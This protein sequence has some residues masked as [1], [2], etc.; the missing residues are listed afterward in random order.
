MR[1]SKGNKKSNFGRPVTYSK[2]GLLWACVPFPP[3]AGGTARDRSSE[4]R[5][6]W[7]RGAQF[8]S[9]KGTGLGRAWGTAWLPAAGPEKLLEPGLAPHQHAQPF[10]YRAHLCVNTP[11]RE[12]SWNN[13]HLHVKPLRYESSY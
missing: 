1:E 4:R 3:A 8:P 10:R 5:W 7:K 6:L 11:Q 12:K 9:K 2:K 13:E